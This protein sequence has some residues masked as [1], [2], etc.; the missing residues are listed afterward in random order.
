MKFSKLSTRDLIL[1][2]L[3]AAISG[4]TYTLLGQPWLALSTAF[5]PL[6]GAAL[7]LF[8]YGHLIAFAFVPRPGVALTVSI[9]STTTQFLIGDPT[10]IAVLGWGVAHGLGA[11][12]V[13]AISRYRSPNFAVFFLAA[14]LG[15]AFGQMFSLYLY[16]WEDTS[17]IFIASLFVVFIA[18]GIESGGLSYFVNQAILRRSKP[19]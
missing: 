1:I 7:G 17:Q 5:G 15:A 14:G 12:L 2:A 3:C 18:S 4:V 9:L 19:D 11:E 10:G 16:G 13:F 6:G 8:Q